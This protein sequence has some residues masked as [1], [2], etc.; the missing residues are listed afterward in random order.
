MKRQ[1]AD[2]ENVLA[3]FI[4]ENSLIS[5]MYKNNLPELNSKANKQTKKPKRKQP[6]QKIGK[7]HFIKEDYGWQL[8]T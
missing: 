1:A 3:N 7:R 2:W 6:N 5:R 4:S 8:N